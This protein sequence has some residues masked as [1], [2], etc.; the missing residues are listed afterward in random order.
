MRSSKLIDKL[1]TNLEPV[2]PLSPLRNTLL[3]VAVSLVSV[4]VILFLMMP[5]RP[6]SQMLEQPITVFSGLWLLVNTIFMAFTANIIGMPGRTNQHLIFAISF[7]FYL[8]LIGVLLGVAITFTSPIV[9]SG[10]ACVKAVI[11]LSIIPLVFFFNIVRKLAPTSPLLMGL[12]LGLS[13]CAM[14]AFGVGFSCANEDPLHLL[15]FHFTAPALLL[16]GLG[17]IIGKKIL[18]W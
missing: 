9:L 16:G 18:K 12:L 4:A 7:A 8:L 13:T 3:W 2:R 11:I 15:F 14:G 6:V 1:T 17:A 10:S 5:Q